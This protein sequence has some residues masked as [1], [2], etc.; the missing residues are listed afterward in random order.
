MAG[1]PNIQQG[2]LNR[3][4][5]SVVIPGNT[6]LNVTPPFLGENMITLAF[7]GQAT[8]TINTATGVIQSGEPYQMVTVTMNLLKSQGLSQAWEAQRQSNTSIGDF[9]VTPD[10]TAG[11]GL[12]PY[13]LNNGAIQNV[14]EL[15]FNGR[16]AGFVVVLT[17]YL[18]IN[19]A[20][21]DA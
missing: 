5:A 8:T 15:N 13:N 21:W 18:P 11:Q 4:R 3:L 14:R 9:T 19:N 20:L 17:A 10:V 12:Q 2:T 1:N 7:D 6:A 16:D